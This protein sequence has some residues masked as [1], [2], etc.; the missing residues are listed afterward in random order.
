M[1]AACLTPSPDQLTGYL[2]RAAASFAP[3]ELAYLALTSKIERPLQD[4]LAWSLHAGLP[5]LVVSREWRKTDI[6]ILSADGKTPRVLLEAKAM[7]SFDLAWEP[8]ASGYPQLMAHD[9][10]KASQLDPEGTAAVYALALVTHPHGLPRDLPGVIKY[11]DRITEATLEV[12]AGPLREIA[13]AT[14][15]RTLPQLGNVRTGALS[16]G[17]AF[18]TKVTIDYWLVGPF[19][20]PDPGHMN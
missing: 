1:G 14:M 19:S 8:N 7:Y 2:E 17:V 11:L 3:G 18:D 15:K 4:R 20:S 16:G 13:A 12:G 10:A 5:G 9:M 6:A